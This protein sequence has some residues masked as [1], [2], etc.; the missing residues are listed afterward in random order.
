MEVSQNAGTPK[1]PNAIRLSR[2][3]SKSR[4]HPAGYPH[5]WKQRLSALHTDVVMCQHQLTQRAVP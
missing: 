2:T 4:N 3:Y 5:L 1:S